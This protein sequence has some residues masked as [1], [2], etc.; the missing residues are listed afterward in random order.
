[1]VLI[2]ERR[3]GQSVVL[4]GETPADDVTVT[5]M[6]ISEKGVSLGVV[7]HREQGIFRDELWKRI[8][9]EKHKEQ[10]NGRTSG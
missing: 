9:S 3:L 2:L 6:G 8:Q 1:M 7:A 4:P 10:E 5:V